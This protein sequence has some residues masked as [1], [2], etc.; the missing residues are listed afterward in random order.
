MPLTRPAL[1][2]C[3][4]AV[5]LL[6]PSAAIA[7]TRP[8][9]N[10][11]PNPT[12]SGDPV[13]IF[14]RATPGAVVRLFHRVNPAPRFTLIQHTTADAAGRYEFTR[15]AGVVTTNR[16]WY[17]VVKRKRSRTVHERVSALVTL[18]GPSDPNLVTGTPYVFT[19]TVSPKHVGQLVQLQRQ[20]ASGPA[21]V[22]HTIDRGRIG[23][24]GAYT[25]TH[26][27]VVPGDANLRVHLRRDARNIGSAS[28]LLSYQIS[29]KQH[30]QLTLMTSLDP[31]VVGQATNLTGTLAGVTAPTPVTLYAHTYRTRF[32]PIA[33]VQTDASGAY[34]FPAQAPIA[35]TSYQVRGGGRRSAV[36]FEGVRDAVTASAS[37]TS[38][39]A[40]DTVTFTGT[41]TPD[42][43][44]HAIILQRQNANG[45]GFHAVERS[46]V[47]A[48]SA[49]SIAH[50][51]TVPGTKVF[52]ILVPGGPINQGGASATITVTVAPNTFPL[53]A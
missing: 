11:A 25:I 1:A 37:A 41:V 13:V 28:D 9:I 47:G 8:T 42:K 29:Q 30:P 15:A 16:N 21:D 36:V 3:V 50:R 10:A 24:D 33:M 22:W 52:R 31:L 23:A 45:H 12:T 35:N 4:A 26:R 17:V 19:G 40:G 44:G 5:A 39:T 38:V 43:T 53:A 34:A 27:F 51:V 18:N 49:F 48:G 20:S 6:L 32:S 2:V 46:T 14:G 7:A